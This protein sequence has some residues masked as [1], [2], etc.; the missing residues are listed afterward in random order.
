[1]DNKDK[2]LF[3]NNLKYTYDRGEVLRVNSQILRH[4]I[5]SQHLGRVTEPLYEFI[6]YASNRHAGKPNFIGFTYKDD[7][8]AYA[9]MQC[10]STVLKFNAEKS[11]NPFAWITS[12]ISGAFVNWQHLDQRKISKD[13]VT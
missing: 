3:W 4:V 10:M 2:Q 7:M 5:I 9:I 8:V 13:N 1:M 12:I 11:E 6:V